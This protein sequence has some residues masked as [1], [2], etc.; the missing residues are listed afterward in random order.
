MISSLEQSIALS[1]FVS[2]FISMFDSDAMSPRGLF[3]AAAKEGSC[4]RGGVAGGLYLAWRHRDGWDVALEKLT[5]RE[6]PS[7]STSFVMLQ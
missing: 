4:V 3:G 6:R 1:F 7:S 5:D 2:L